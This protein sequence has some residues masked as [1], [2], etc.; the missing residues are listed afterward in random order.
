M[1]TLEIT[2]LALNI[3]F[4]IPLLFKRGPARLLW[5][6]RTRLLLSLAA[7]VVGVLQLMLEGSRW[8]L[9][10]AYGLTA[11]YLITSL[12]Q[13]RPANAQELRTGGFPDLDTA[14]RRAFW[15]PGSHP[16][17]GPGLPLPGSQAACADRALQGR[18]DRSPLY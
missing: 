17:R 12:W 2:L 8:Q 18:N 10:P 13:A 15:P 7:A 3:P 1:R 16:E 5:Q 6:P 11:V 9:F 14:G 4:L